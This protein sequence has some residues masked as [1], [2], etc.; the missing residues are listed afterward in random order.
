MGDIADMM[1]GGDLCQQCGVP[2]TNSLGDFPQFCPDCKPRKKR[3]KKRRRR[4]K[5]DISAPVVSKEG[6]E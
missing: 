4:N 2:L 6:A 1:I 5:P 3:K